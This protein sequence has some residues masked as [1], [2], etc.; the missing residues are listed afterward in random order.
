[1]AEDN[2]PAPGLTQG[3]GEDTSAGVNAKIRNNIL[4]AAQK[5]AGS[6]GG[7]AA[8][9]KDPPVYLGFELTD[10]DLKEA[11]SQGATVTNYLPAS[12]VTQQFYGWDEATKNK[13]LMQLSLAGYDNVDQAP[14]G[15]LAEL[16]GAYVDQAGKYNAAGVKM[17]PWDILAK[18]I[19]QKEKAARVQPR[20]VTT[21]ST[22]LDVSSALSARA[23]F[24]QATHALLGRAP[25]K[26]ETK[27]FQARL[28]AYEQANPQVTTTTTS[29]AGGLATDPNTGQVTGQTSKTTGGVN[30]AERA[31]MA[32]DAVKVDP[33][34][35]A[36]QAASNGMNWLMEMVNGG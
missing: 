16:W 28:N 5:M 32:E 8:N 12:Q 10:A 15:K 27:L 36:Y 35:G 18:D 1:M 24:Q 14:D 3:P 7:S 20:S 23:I 9:P 33:E 21:T 4:G 19:R 31:M 29:Y 13:F 17:T 26:A 22:N 30:A 2:T 6:L 25:T 11:R 34:Y